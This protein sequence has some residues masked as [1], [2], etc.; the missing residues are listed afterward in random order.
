MDNL[1]GDLKYAFR[2]LRKNPGI[3]A[4]ALLTLAL[5]I[6]A[7]TAIFTVVNAVVLRPLPFNEAHE[8]VS[9][10]ENHPSVEGYC[11]ASPP[12]VEDWSEQSETIEDLGLGRG[13]AFILKGEA[14]SESVR[15]GIA[16]PGFFRV[17]QLTPQVGRLFQPLD[18]EEGNRQVVV[19]SYRLWQSRFGGSNDILG[20]QITLDD[21]S[22]SV[23][24]VLPPQ[25]QV[26]HLE[27]I[28]IWTPLPFDPKDEE[29]REWRGFRAIG[30]LA[31]RAS[32]DEAQLEMD[33][34]ARRMA[35][36]HPETSEGWDISV[37][38]LHDQ[39]VGSARSILWILLGAVGFVLL[40]GCANV[41][42]LLL[43][44]AAQRRRE[45]AVR[46]ALGAGRDRLLRLLLTES[47]ILSI[48][49]G[50]AGLLLALWVT[51]VFLS[52][53]PSGI[54]RLDEVSLDGRV[55]GFTLLLSILTSA[56]FGLVPCFHASKIDLNRALKE[57]EQ[58]LLG[59][60]RLGVRG[61]LVAS[62]TALALVLL[63]S[64]TLLI[65][66]FLTL[67]RWE[68]G[69]SRDDLLTVWLLSSSGK[70]QSGDE[71]A[72]LYQGAVDEVRSLPSVV[73]AGAA[74]AGPMF[75]GRE[76]DELTIGGREVPP[77]GERPVARWF[78]VSPG[79]FQTLGVPLVRGR[80]FSTV[81]M[82]EASPVAIINDS[83][84]RRLWPDRSPLG[85]QVTMS[86][87][88]MT[89]V[90]VVGDVQ[91]FQP[92]DHIENE[93]YWP[94]RQA[95]RY[96]TFL[97]IRTAQDPQ[98]VVRPVG[99]RLHELD[100]DMSLSS[101]TTMNER[102]GRQL[103]S[104]RFN[105]LL[106]GSFACVALLLAAVGVYGVVSYSVSQNT[107]EIGVRMALG[108]KTRDVLRSVLA[109]GM[110]PALVGVMVGLVGSFFATRVLSSLLFGIAPTD[111]PTFVSVAA[112]LVVVA[113]LACFI[114]ARR[115][116]R[117]DAMETLRH[118]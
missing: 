62:E 75:G 60:A 51:E 103:V 46:A 77:A 88:Q 83:M 73:S 19:L 89:I 74:S 68:P 80:D 102:M 35:Q 25:T 50:A 31:E 61:V 48:I 57:G 33:V 37:E 11:I 112:V 105:T 42:N 12:N 117:V 54:P 30:R 82:K 18:V 113:M 59:R 47:F 98:S 26:P 7:N 79:Y 92:G 6:G 45:F 71:V 44:R 49:G 95:P 27:D 76:T 23:V 53:A 15:G 14:G 116:T 115:A 64:A 17:L 84:A 90:G 36:Q 96:A 3:T 69:F 41:A 38:P 43:A 91:P 65:Q 39:V 93:I 32:R 109:Q 81:D 110:L 100:P 78:D 107:R 72:A 86:N 40:I 63:I 34:I 24:G 28:D 108:A 118:E 101:F 13:W 55:L 66:S 114:P 9:L 111:P 52:L 58:R 2:L 67:T 21:E 10:C 106:L 20:Q 1:L 85:E 70:Y 16:T 104:P 4:I 8:L 94:Q 97:L 56:I 99:D 29:N 22:F 5:G 87:R